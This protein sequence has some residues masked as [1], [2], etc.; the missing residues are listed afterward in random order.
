[1]SFPGP[2]RSPASYSE[3][4]QDPLYGGGAETLFIG[5]EAGRLIAACQ[6]HPLRQW[7]TG[8]SY[9]CAGVGTV[10]ISPTHRK[11][12]LAAELITAALRAARERGDLVSA[13]Y[14]FR[15]SFY[16]KLG[17]GDAG[18][19]L[20]YQIPPETL[21]DSPERSRVAVLDTDHERGEALRLYSRW[22]CSQTGQI[23]RTERMWTYSCT[24][25]GRALVGYRARN[26][27]LEGYALV[28]YCAGLPPSERYLEVNELVW[29]TTEARRGLYA[30][31]ASLGDQWRQLLIRA[32]PSQNLGD[33]LREPRL[34]LGAAPLWGLW[35]P[36][37]TLLLGPMFRIVHLQA[38]WEQRRVAPEPSLAVTLE[39]T[40]Q[41]LEENSGT[42]HLAFDHG[43]VSVAPNGQSNA[44]IRMDI[45]T[46][47][48]LLIGSLTT[49]NGL[50]AG[51]LEC[52]RPDVLP[53]LDALI[54]VPEPWMYDRF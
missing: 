37:A 34:P 18:A 29:T 41:N 7:L 14:P 2:N 1:H 17:Y 19:A 47:S 20:Q 22:I 42:W 27:Q 51:L 15:V 30:W 16:R 40:D 38:A 26:D 44:T 53:R 36:A 32:L 35:M 33:W 25:S 54:A 11:R 49:A 43:R 5:E 9:P 21:P 3:Q 10:A 6:L 50:A 28:T 48:R 31:L 12:G 45:S 39:I 46:L 8:V 24:Q 23:E 4:L 13:L 52:D